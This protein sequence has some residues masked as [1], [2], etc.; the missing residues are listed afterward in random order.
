MLGVYCVLSD[1]KLIDVEGF[2]PSFPKLIVPALKH[3]FRAV[4]MS[5]NCC[6]DLLEQLDFP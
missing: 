1:A 5:P 2:A 6:K 4:K 3:H